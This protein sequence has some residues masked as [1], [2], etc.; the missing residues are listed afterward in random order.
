MGKTALAIGMTARAFR[1]DTSIS[2]PENGLMFFHSSS[3][4][5]YQ[6]TPAIHKEGMRAGIIK[7]GHKPNPSARLQ[8]V[9]VQTVVNRLFFPLFVSGR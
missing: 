3:S 8:I 5:A 1:H 6:P 4:G 7:T 2:D 9:S